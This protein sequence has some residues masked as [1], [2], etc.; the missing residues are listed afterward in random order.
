MARNTEDGRGKRV[1]RGRTQVSQALVAM[2]VEQGRMPS[3]EEVAARAGVS[4]R[5][6]FRYF[7]GVEALE[8]ETARAMRA[9]MT[10]RVPLPEA[11]GSLD[12]RLEVLVWHRARLYE[13]ISPVRRFLDAA[14]Q[15]GNSAFHTFIRD[16][17]R[18]LRAHLRTVVGPELNAQPELLPILEL[19]TSWEAWTSLRDG[20]GCSVAKARNIVLSG[21]KAQLSWVSRPARAARSS[22]GTR[23]PAPTGQAR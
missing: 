23:R 7:D 19:L 13:R 9:L 16:G 15:R 2:V 14:R 11:E 4:R 22:K 8:V 21:L 5:S 12:A 10:E 17:Q 1:V 3:V 6:V 18:M 20:Q